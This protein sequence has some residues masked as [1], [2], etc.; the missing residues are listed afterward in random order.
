MK[1]FICISIALV[2]LCLSFTSCDSYK[3]GDYHVTETKE[4][5]N[6]VVIE[7]E[8]HGKILVEL[9]PDTAPETVKNFKELVSEGFYDGLIFHRVISGFMV[10]GGDPK[11]NGTGGSGKNIKG[12]FAL[13]GVENNLKHERGVIS[14]ARGGSEA[15]QFLHYGYT[16]NDLP[17]D[18]RASIL[19]DFNSA[20]S[21]FFIMHET[22]SHLDGS[23]A[24]FGRVIYGMDVVDS[25][26][27][28]KTDDNDK[29]INDVK[30]SSVKFVTVEK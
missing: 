25:I 17:D 6:Y 12:E 22:S 20:S 16:M 28:E 7:V 1:K 19:E 29:P 21:Q 27:A 26:A 8:A 10:Q 18:V 11:G 24:A 13:N 5:T 3:L 30:I 14:M 4:E 23:Y 2:L 9:Y 15:E